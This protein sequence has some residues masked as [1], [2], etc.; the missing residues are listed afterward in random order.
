MGKII[1]IDLGTTNSCVSVMEGGEAKVIANP[2][3]SRTTPSVV[4]FK[5]DERQVGD[6]AKRQAITN[7]NT[8]MSIKRHMGTNHKEVIDGKE[9]T[10]QEISAIILQNLKAT[11]EAYLG[12]PVTEAVITVPAYFNDAERQAT[13]DAGRIAGLDVKRIINEPTAAALAYGLDKTDKEQIILVYDL[14]G[15]TFDATVMTLKDGEVNIKSSLGDKSIGGFDFENKI[16]ELV[17]EEFEK[18]S[19]KKLYTDKSAMQDLRQKAEQAK[20]NLSVRNKSKINITSRGYTVEVEITPEQFNHMI[21]SLI[22]KTIKIMNYA[23]KQ[24][25]LLWKDIDKILL[26][27]GSTRIKKVAEDIERLIGIKPSREI[28]PDEAVAL[29]AAIQANIS[30]IKRPMKVSDVSAHSLGVK[31]STYKNNEIIDKN[32]I[33]I[34]K[35]TKLPYEKGIMLKTVIDNQENY[36]LILTEGESQDI[37]FVKVIGTANIKLNRRPKGSLIKIKLNYDD[38]SIVNISVIDDTDD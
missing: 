6:V 7:P 1:G 38:N 26:V 20:K 32:C 2:E 28:N 21:S 9:Y 15:G 35:N 24:S 17:I 31:V 23:V 34:P 4:S 25:G 33:V 12:E 18:I 37:D 10:P 14:G 19:N 3:G 27:G 36:N 16:I 22:E 8:I 13:K 5:G 29:G 11:A 30:N